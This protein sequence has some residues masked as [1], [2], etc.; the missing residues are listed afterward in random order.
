MSYLHIQNNKEH[1]VNCLSEQRESAVEILL[2]TSPLSSLRLPRVS[3]LPH[4]YQFEDLRILGGNQFRNIC[5]KGILLFFILKEGQI[6]KTT[7]R[8]KNESWCNCHMPLVGDFRHS[9]RPP[10]QLLSRLH[11][12]IQEEPLHLL[13]LGL[14]KSCSFS[15]LCLGKFP[16]TLTVKIHQ[17]L[18]LAAF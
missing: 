11:P 18:F 6:E 2:I 14:H 15:R 5:N 12:P 16:Q 10:P 4:H 1:Y 8:F 13:G 9:P 17:T 3:A 7:L